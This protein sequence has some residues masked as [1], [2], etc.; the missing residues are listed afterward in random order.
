MVSFVLETVIRFTHVS[1]GDPEKRRIQHQEGDYMEPIIMQA[2]VRDAETILKL[3]YLC[4]QTQAALYND[5]TLPPLTESLT[6]LL[7]EYDT[8][9][10][11]VARLGEEVVG[12]V[13]GQ[14]REG[15]C[16]I[17]RL[18]VHPRLQ[19]H[20][21]GTR[22]MY[23]IEG[24]FHSATRYELFTG[25]RSERNLHLYHKLG[26]TRFREETVSP[27]LRFVYLEKQISHHIIYEV[28]KE[29]TR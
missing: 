26:Y 4:Y 27:Q 9:S 3:Q 13:R 1:Q 25:Y 16:H 8:H 2:R 20:G 28:E 21:L 6:A 17:G 12:S 29:R 24:H 23:A 18:I 15:T 7:F 22:L 10:I 14:L 11:L 19:G 5:Y